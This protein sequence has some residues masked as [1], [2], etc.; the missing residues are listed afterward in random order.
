MCWS[1]GAVKRPQPRLQRI[2]ESKRAWSILHERLELGPA[3][4]ADSLDSGHLNITHRQP[5]GQSHSCF[6]NV[7]AIN[8][9][10]VS[11]R[12]RGGRTTCTLEIV[13][14]AAGLG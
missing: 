12:E 13:Q 9:A 5:H 14:D 8:I 10:Y 2:L 4:L 3:R 11:P 7:A 6:H 1:V